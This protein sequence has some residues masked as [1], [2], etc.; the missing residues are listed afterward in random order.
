MQATNLKR[1]A[2]THVGST[3]LAFGIL[4][5]SLTAG[6]TLA[7]TGDLPGIGDDGSVQQT[8]TGAPT[9]AAAEASQRQLA[10]ERAEYADWRAT[11]M[12]TGAS[13][14]ESQSRMDSDVLHNWLHSQGPTDTLQAQASQMDRADYL[15]WRHS[16]TLP[17]DEDHDR[18]DTHASDRGPSPDSR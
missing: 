12:P 11:A 3:A 7:L 13:A 8:T 10:M 1:Y 17:D 4:V 5:G 15:T 18:S 6:M 9:L 14:A 16:D 2:V